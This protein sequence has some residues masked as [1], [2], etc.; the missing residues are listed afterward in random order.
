[1][2]KL[3][4]PD[5]IE[6]ACKQASALLGNDAISTALC[7]IGLKASPSLIDKWGDMDAVQTP[8]LAQALAL[9]NLL[10]KNGHARIFGELF[11]RL[12]PQ[13]AQPEREPCDPLREAMRATGHAA[14]L[15]EQVDKAM[16]DGRI[17]RG[18][19]NRIEHL[20]H[21]AQRQLARFR[22]VVRAALGAAPTRGK[23]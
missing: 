1:M 19:L 7:A 14:T 15:M 23:A 21:N 5:S 8:S 9:E 3:R 20:T 4:T 11:D 6:D 16:I 10:I 17:D 2:T 18:E 22:R 13:Q 12:L